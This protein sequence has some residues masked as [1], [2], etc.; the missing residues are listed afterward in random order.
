MQRAIENFFIKLSS[1]YNEK[2]F[3]ILVLQENTKVKIESVLRELCGEDCKLEIFQEDNSD[4]IIVS[5]KYVE[6]QYLF[7][8]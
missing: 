7:L 5:G 8:W 6:G 4:E 2:H 3:I 1:C